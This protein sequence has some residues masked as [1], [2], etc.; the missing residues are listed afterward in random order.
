MMAPSYFAVVNIA[1]IM[2]SC[3]LEVRLALRLN[4]KLAWDHLLM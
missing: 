3:S 4:I 2:Y 1:L